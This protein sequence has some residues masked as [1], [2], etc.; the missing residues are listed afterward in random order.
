MERVSRRLFRAV[1]RDVF[2]IS[3]RIED[4]FGESLDDNL[5]DILEMRPAG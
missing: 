5:C 3:S 4:V 1:F 2:I